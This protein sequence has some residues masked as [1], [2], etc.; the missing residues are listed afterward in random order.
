MPRLPSLM[1]K[2]LKGG[3]AASDVS[4]ILTIVLIFCIENVHNCI[5]NFITYCNNVLCNT[6]GNA[7]I[8][9]PYSTRGYDISNPSIYT[10]YK[11]VFVFKC[12]TF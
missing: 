1:K 4:G 9:I 8:Y 6:S 12:N 7:T 5:L 10:H 2:L 11:H 3:S